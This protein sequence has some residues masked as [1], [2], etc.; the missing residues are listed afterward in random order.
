[1]ELDCDA[2]ARARVCLCACVL[3]LYGVAPSQEETTQGA[4][5]DMQSAVI[6]V[7]IILL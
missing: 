7:D 6:T 2:S 1:M 4:L 5:C 3:Q